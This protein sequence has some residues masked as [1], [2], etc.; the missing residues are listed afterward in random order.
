MIA[1][2]KSSRDRRKIIV[3]D[4]ETLPDL[5]QVLKHLPKID[6]WNGNSLKASINSTL[7]IGYKELGAKQTKC[8]NAWDYPSW[9]DSVNND[10]EL[11]KDFSKMM[12]DVAAIITHNGKKFDWKFLQTRLLVNDLPQLP[13]DIIHIDTRELSKRYLYSIS[14]RLNDVA[15]LTKAT[16]KLENGGWELWEKVW[17]KEPKALKLMEKYCKQDV[18]TLEE[19]YTKLRPFVKNLPNAN[20]FNMEKTACPTC[21]S[22][23]IQKDGWRTTKTER[24]QRLRCTDCG[25]CSFL[26][27][28]GKMVQV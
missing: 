6:D 27:P 1:M 9:N 25:S 19:V 24:Y 26:K 11:L 10:K 21:G 7:C 12:K 3:L 8:M 20:V 2:S 28:K 18:K 4:I 17:R 15:E 22:L 13:T 23:A 16:K 5:P 14:N